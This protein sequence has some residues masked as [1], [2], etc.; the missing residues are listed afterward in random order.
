MNERHLTLST[1]DGHTLNVRTFVPGHPRAVLI[2]S[3]GMA[4]HGARY[5]AL[6]RWLADRDLAVFTYHHR[7]HGP[8]CPAQDLGHYADQNGWQRVVDDLHR[9]L[10]SARQQ[11]PGLP[12]NL[13]GH[14]MGSFIAQ[15][16]A[17]QYPT[18]LD[19]LI[20]SATN[21]IHHPSLAVSRLLV[22]LIAA[23]RGRRHRS[24]L[25]SKLTFE[26]FNRAFAPNRTASDW[27]S[28]DPAQVDLYEADPLC[29]FHCSAGLWRDLIGGM[30]SI[31]PAQWRRD[32]PVHML[33]GTEDPVGEMGKGVRRH[34]RAIRDAGVERLTLRLFD[35]GRHELLNESNRM[36]VWQYLLGLCDIRSSAGV[37]AGSATEASTVR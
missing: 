32:L 16:C 28:R 26:K 24:P 14:S 21:R 23:M 15:A 37:A 36:E 4:E 13:L 5:Q 8:D 34:F 17:Q 6:A 33:S 9:V 25:I 27:L 7:G 10:Q 35:G 1:P 19:T 30:L 2:I 31:D 11:F 20:L 18:A 29:G 3:H 12:V 22:S